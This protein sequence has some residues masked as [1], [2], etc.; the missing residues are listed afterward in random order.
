MPLNK[1]DL[2]QMPTLQQM[3][4]TLKKWFDTVDSL[5][6]DC[7]FIQA[8][9]SRSTMHGARPFW[10]RAARYDCSCW[11][12]G[13]SFTASASQIAIVLRATTICE[14]LIEIKR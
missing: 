10:R 11:R 1:I 8:A 5:M 13:T 6:C 2:H 9:V 4:S 7:S 14:V 12:K 3:P